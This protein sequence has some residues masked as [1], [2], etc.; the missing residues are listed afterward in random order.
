MRTI[1]EQIQSLIDDLPVMKTELEKALQ[2]PHYSSLSIVT[3]H[4][5]YQ[6]RLIEGIVAQFD[7]EMTNGSRTGSS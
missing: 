4:H 5:E 2:S 3:R 1:K 6:R 7:Q